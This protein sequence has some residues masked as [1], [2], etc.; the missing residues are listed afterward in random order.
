MLVF[1]QWWFDAPGGGLT[2]LLTQIDA[3][4]VVSSTGAPWWAARLVMGD[5]VRRQ[6]ARGVKPWIC[7]KAT[8]RMLTLHN[9]DRFTPAKGSVFLDRLE[10]A[11]QRF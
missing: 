1:P 5:P 2:P 8:F 10:Q 6:I 4:W 3:L 11:F 9:M 7:P